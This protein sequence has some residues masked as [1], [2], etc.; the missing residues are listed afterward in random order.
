MLRSVSFVSLVLVGCFLLAGCGPGSA[1][2]PPLQVDSASQKHRRGD[3]S[4][5]SHPQHG[6]NG[7][8][9]IEL[10]SH[11][12]HAELIHNDTTSAVTVHMLDAAAKSL[13]A[14]AQRQIVIQ[15]LRGEQV[16]RFVLEARPLQAETDGKASRFEIVDTELCDALH[17]QNKL[18]AQLQVTIDGKPF[19]G[20]IGQNTA[21]QKHDH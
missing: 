9:L 12:Y 16:A 19:S 8:H 5:Q 6:P 4:H 1:K 14:I 2:A 15:L 18:K 20:P 17:R 13:V 10:G 7:G 3:D 21:G 11:D